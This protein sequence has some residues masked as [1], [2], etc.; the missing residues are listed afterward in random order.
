MKVLK[1]AMETQNWALAAHVMIL[2]TLQVKE[3]G[4]GNE[5]KKPGSTPRQPKRP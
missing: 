3:N 1:V 5:K 4:E 2:A